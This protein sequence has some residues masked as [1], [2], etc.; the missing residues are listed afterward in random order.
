MDN[1]EIIKKLIDGHSLYTYMIPDDTIPTNRPLHCEGFYL[2]HT[3]IIDNIFWAMS[4]SVHV[5]DITSR[6][7]PGIMCNF[8]YTKGFGGIFCSYSVPTKGVVFMQRSRYKRHEFITKNSWELIWDSDFRETHPL[9]LVHEVIRSGA[10]LKIA[11]QDTENIWNIHPIDLPMYLI[12]SETLRLKTEYFEYPFVFRTPLAIDHL[13][14][15][16]E[17]YFSRKTTSNTEGQLVLD[18]RNQHFKC[19]YNLCSDGSYYNLYDIPRKT[20][21]KYRRLKVFCEGA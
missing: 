10:R 15:K 18:C 6:G 17:A 8:C 13:I 9:S 11:M 5:A 20:T 12:E 2:P 1:D 7:I 21:Q 3:L 16:H 14:Q 19:F 4:R